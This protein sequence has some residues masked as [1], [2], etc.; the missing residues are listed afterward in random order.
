MV[1]EL[2]RQASRLLEPDVSLH[3]FRTKDQAEVDVIAEAADGRIVA[4][5]AKAG[6]VSRSAIRALASLRDRFD[7]RG[8]H[9]VRGV[10][11]YLGEDAF[12]AGDRLHVL[13]LSHLWNSRPRLR[14]C[15]RLIRNT[16]SS[17]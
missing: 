3:H 6:R 5:E 11:F 9:F 14:E 2:I 7:A 16:H 10:V 17:K 1:T 13:P 15:R 8:G 12:P 4:V